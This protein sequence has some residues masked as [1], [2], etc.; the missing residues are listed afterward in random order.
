VVA[1]GTTVVITLGQ[2]QNNP[3][4]QNPSASVSASPN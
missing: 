2:R 3:P 1:Q 4:T